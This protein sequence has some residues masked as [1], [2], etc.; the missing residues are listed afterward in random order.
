MEKQKIFTIAVTKAMNKNTFRSLEEQHEIFK[1]CVDLSTFKEHIERVC[2]VHGINKEKNQGYRAVLNFRGEGGRLVVE[3]SL[4][5][6]AV[7]LRNMTVGEIVA[8]RFESGTLF[9]EIKSSRKLKQPDSV[10][11]INRST[12]IREGEEEGMFGVVCSGIKILY[13]K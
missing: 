5:E 11:F 10:Y 4:T 13:N 8:V 1:R 3:R 6:K 7:T 2:K 9:I 12:K